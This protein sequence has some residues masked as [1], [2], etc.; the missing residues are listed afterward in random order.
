MTPNVYQFKI[1]LLGIKPLIWR[2][3]RVYHDITFRQLHNIV[4]I[5]MGWENSHLFQFFWGYTRFTDSLLGA[6]DKTA[7]N[8]MGEFITQ[9]GAILGYEY[10]FG[11]GWQHELVL[12]KILT[13]TPQPCP[14]CTH[15]RR[16]CPPED[17]G[18]TWG[19][20]ELVKAMKAR[21]GYRYREY[22]EWLG[23]YFDAN[24]FELEAINA[25]LA[26]PNVW[27]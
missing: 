27:R 3:F 19:Y 11:D 21:R 14:I 26:Q 6:E 25:S 17:C 15:G 7:S 1:T 8:I 20:R 4:Q 10:D 13:R 24:T 2:R 23:G 18:G 16:A 5:T 22:K 9:E 12:E